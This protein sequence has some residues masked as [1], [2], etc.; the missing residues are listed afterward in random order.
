M[1]FLI[2]PH[3]AICLKWVYESRSMKSL[4]CLSVCRSEVIKSILA[5][6]RHSKIII[7]MWEVR[8]LLIRKIKFI[9][10]ADLDLQEK[11]KLWLIKYKKLDIPDSV[12]DIIS[13]FY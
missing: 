3:R 5:S 10:M 6:A 4:W 12:K 11:S 8:S 1:S 13:S 9:N 7:G 2:D